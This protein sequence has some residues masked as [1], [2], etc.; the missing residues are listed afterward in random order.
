[1]QAYYFEGDDGKHALVI[2]NDHTVTSRKIQVSLRGA[3][4]RS[5]DLVSGEA[6]SQEQNITVTLHP[7]DSGGQTLQFFTWENP[8]PSKPP[9]IR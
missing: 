3:N 6:V 2:W 7:R 4:Q 8:D 5:Y 9:R 1:V